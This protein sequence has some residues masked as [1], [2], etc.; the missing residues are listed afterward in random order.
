MAT[1]EIDFAAALEGF[2][3][4]VLTPGDGGYEDARRIHNGLIDKRPALIT[5]CRGAGDIVAAVNLARDRG[6]ELSVRGGGHNVSGKA[7]TEGG[8][9]LDLSLMRGIFVDPTACTARAQG[10]VTWAELN[11]ETQLFGLAVTGG[12]VST[13]GIAGLTLG[14]GLGWIMGK[15]GLATDNLVSAQ[16]V[17]ADGSVLTAS[18]GENADLFWG[19]RGG[20][21][22]FGVVASFEY[23]LHTVGPLVTGGL[24]VY[25]FDAG[26]DVLRFY[27]EFTADL[28]EE[29]CAFAGFSHAPD[30]SGA[31]IAAILVC[32]VGTPEQAEKDLASLLGFGSP[33]DVLVGPMP[34]SALNAMLDASYPKGALN[35]WKS[36]FVRELSDDAIDTLV[37]QFAA[38]PGPLTGAVFEHFHGEV[39]RV[40]VGAMAVPHREAGYNLVA[41]SVWMDPAATDEN[42]EWTR[43]MYA[44][45]TPFF[46]G[47]RYVNY[48]DEDDTG[49]AVRAAF[50]PNYTR[51]VELKRQYDPA[52]L[53]RLNQNVEP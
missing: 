48:L 42:V 23:G 47:R 24:V 38:C 20:G 51:L 43:T 17:T 45:M 34:Y 19:L 2:A 16:V 39:T 12:I 46:A 1:T 50:G 22:N 26:G 18:E 3:G 53:F 8:L 49:D 52:N 9:M 25:P 31:K 41:T 35:Y 44:A 30:G 40:P 4:E 28:P 5:R 33:L 29:L 13:T 7:V 6:L 21:G 27:R 37:E 32:H 11:R 14:G 15:Y 10:G 36:S